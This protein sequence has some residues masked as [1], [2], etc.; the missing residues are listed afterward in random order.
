MSNNE[1]II[2]TLTG[3]QTPAGE[4]IPVSFLVYKGDKETYITFQQ[5]DKYPRLMADDEC[6]YSAPRYDI[7]I[8]T[9]SNFLDIVKVVKE[10]MTSAGWTWIED[11]ADL[12]EA[13][14][15][16]FHKVCTFEIENY[17]I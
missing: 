5:V 3:I 15:Q 8:Y 16:Y 13:D 17:K 12:Y 7:D 10:R 1:N 14:T 2:E 9:K 4:I 6:E 11:S